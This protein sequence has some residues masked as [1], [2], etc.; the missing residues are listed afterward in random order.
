QVHRGRGKKAVAGREAA[1]AGLEAELT[2]AKSRLHSTLG[3]MEAS[4]EEQK[5]I[6][7]ELQSTN[8]EMQSTNEEL[9]TSKEELQSLNEELTTLNSE[10]EQ[11]IEELSRSHDDMANLLNGTDIAMVFL[12]RDLNVRRFTQPVTGIINLL[13]NDIGR[14]IT[15]LATNLAGN[16]LG[17]DV[18]E[19]LTTLVKKEIPVETKDNR[20]YVMRVLPYRTSDNIIDGAILTF[21]DITAIKKLEQSLERARQ[22]EENIIETIR[23]PL[24]VLDSDLRVRSASR[25]FYRTFQVRP[26]ETVGKLFYSIGSRQWDIPEL[27]RLLEE[28]IP[29]DTRFDDF[30]VDHDFAGIGRRVM[31]LN[32]RKI[33]SKD[34]TE[35]FIL[36]AI[37][38]ASA[39]SKTGR[40]KRPIL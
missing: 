27:R 24:V 8:E 15:D 38:V 36:L 2:L 29:K 3:E 6:T 39:F 23:E 13:A 11:K 25:S 9:T 37:E 16:H 12:D 14:P 31:Y 33:Q 4:R 10:L 40:G 28:I 34:P 5:A 1:C 21:Q 7:E 26:E 17:R 18:R 20:W 22:Y 32:A 35:E 30:K 19:V